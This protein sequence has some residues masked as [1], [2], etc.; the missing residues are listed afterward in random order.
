MVDETSVTVVVDAVDD[1]AV[2]VLVLVRVLAPP[3]PA[4]A[5]AAAQ[6]TAQ[7]TASGVGFIAGTVALTLLRS[8][9]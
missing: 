3:Q 2:P 6:A 1:D 5:T 8:R 4:S 7:A 9:P